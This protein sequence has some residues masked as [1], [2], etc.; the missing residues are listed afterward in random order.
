MTEASFATLGTIYH[1]LGSG[2]KI[3]SGFLDVRKDFDTVWI[4][5]LLY[6]FIYSQS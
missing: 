2:C 5:G 4:D 6:K 1:T 3:F